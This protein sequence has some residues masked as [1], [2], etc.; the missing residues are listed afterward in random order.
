MEDLIGIIQD[1]QELWGPRRAYQELQELLELWVP[2][3]LI[4]NC[5]NYS[6]ITGIMGTQKGLLGIT[7][8]MGTQKGLL[9]IAK[10]FRTYGNYGKPEGQGDYGIKYV[11]IS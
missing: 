8:I 3:G 9:G 1:L 10:L 5:G 7:G 11:I 4:R 2:E 6:G